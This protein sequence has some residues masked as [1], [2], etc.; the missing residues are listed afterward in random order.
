MDAAGW[1]AFFWFTIAAG[2]PG[3]LLL[4]RFAPLGVREPRFTVETAEV[5]RRMTRRQI[6]RRGVIGAVVTAVV[7]GAWM[8]GLG[9]IK[10]HRV[11]AAAGWDFGAAAADFFRPASVGGWTQLVAVLVV[12]VLGGLGTAALFT[13]RHGDRGPDREGSGA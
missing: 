10:A 6:A 8:I 11:N 13:A 4:Q 5:R 2:V 3:L 9:A 1:R 7:S 12:G